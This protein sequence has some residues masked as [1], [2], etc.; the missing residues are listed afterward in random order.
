[1]WQVQPERLHDQGRATGCAR[2]RPAAGVRLER[3]GGG[4]LRKAVEGKCA[5][6]LLNTAVNHHLME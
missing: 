4:G 6:H 3:H 2:E 1:M 5:S